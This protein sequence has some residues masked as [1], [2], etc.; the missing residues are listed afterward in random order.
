MIKLYS[1]F[2]KTPGVFRI[3][4]ANL[5]DRI[6]LDDIL[7]MP[8]VLPTEQRVYPDGNT[9]SILRLDIEDEKEFLE[10]AR[11]VGAEGVFILYDTN[12]LIFTFYDITG[13]YTARPMRLDLQQVAQYMMWEF[14]VI[15][16]DAHKII[17]AVMEYRPK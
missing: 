17:D 4:I 5:T 3:P 15:D 16:E 10:A 2:N 11:A 13:D 9:I 8:G 6:Y 1:D 12:E 14:L 7:H